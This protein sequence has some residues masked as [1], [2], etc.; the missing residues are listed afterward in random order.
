M[1]LRHYDL[2]LL[3]AGY[4]PDDTEAVPGHLGQGSRSGIPEDAVESESSESI[5]EFWLG[6]RWFFLSSRN[7]L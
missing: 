4:Q 6:F 5:L 7:D 3:F 2:V 1:T